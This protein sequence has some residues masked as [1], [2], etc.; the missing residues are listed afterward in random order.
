M[1]RDETRPQPQHTTPVGVGHDE[2][3]TSTLPVRPV[4]LDAGA[5]AQ[6]VLPTTQAQRQAQA[7]KTSSGWT[8][9]G[10]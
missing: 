8:M 7:A 1:E 9:G 4:G 6:P 10:V 3:H 2:P 5:P